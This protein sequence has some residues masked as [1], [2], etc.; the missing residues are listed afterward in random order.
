MIKAI[1]YKI[2]F[3]NF[4]LLKSIYK[5]TYKHLHKFLSGFREYY[6]EEYLLINF[7]LFRNPFL[8][9]AKTWLKHGEKRK[10]K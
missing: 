7:K 1:P 5:K 9:L 6:K 10:K 2:S 8:N 3:D 4:L